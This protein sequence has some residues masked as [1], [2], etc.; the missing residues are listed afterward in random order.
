MVVI[1]AGEF[2]MGTPATEAEREPDEFEHTVTIAKPFA[3]GK[4]E[5]TWD[6]WEACVRDGACDGAGVDAALRLDFEG[7][8]NPNYKDSGRGTRPVVGLSWY[9]AQRYVGWLNAKTGN[10]D[11][12]RLASEAEWEY[13]ARAGT[14]TAYPWGETLDHERGNFGRDGHE[15]GPY[16][17]GRDVWDNETAPVGSF[18]PNGFGL[19]DMYGNTFEWVEDCYLADL[20][21]GPSDGSANKNGSCATREFRS[22]TFISN[23]HMH[24]SGNRIAGYVPTTRGRNYLSFRVAKTLE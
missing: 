5:V 21:Q 13:A 6:Q 7:K 10:D 14:Q 24:R 20:R 23:P 1:P 3:L 9:D 15:L 12:Y 4:T 17:G 16:T 8:P 11:A 22:G 19:Y 18:P 2:V